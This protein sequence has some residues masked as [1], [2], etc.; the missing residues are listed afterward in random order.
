MTNTLDLLAAVRRKLETKSV[1]ALRDVSFEGRR[2]R[3][4]KSENG[5]ENHLLK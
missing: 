3:A 5:P 4:G 2:E 1:G